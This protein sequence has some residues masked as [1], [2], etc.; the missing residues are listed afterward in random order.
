MK[1]GGKINWDEVAEFACSIL[2]SA[3]CTGSSDSDRF[4]NEQA[5][6]CRQKVKELAKELGLKVSDDPVRPLN[7]RRA[8][9]ARMAAR[10]EIA[11]CHAIFHSL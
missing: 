1:H 10:E 8:H 5:T 11:S 4:L 2:V 6:R 7:S 3:K 9:S